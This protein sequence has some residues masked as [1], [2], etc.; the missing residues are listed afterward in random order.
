T[1][2][3]ASGLRGAVAY[4]LVVNLPR[5]DG[6]GTGIDALETATLL[7]VVV[8]TLILGSATEPL[9]RRLDLVGKDDAALYGMALVEDDAALAWSVGWAG[10][11]ER[12]DGARPR[13]VR[14]EV[15]ERSWLH[16]RFKDVD[17]LV[18]KPLFGGRKNGDSEWTEVTDRGAN[19]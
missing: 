12:P 8:S 7:I 17:V 19:G 9:L 11:H 16:D 10:S 18:L 13:A 6:Q 1:L 15:S 2:L 4:G 14:L 3:W 5:A